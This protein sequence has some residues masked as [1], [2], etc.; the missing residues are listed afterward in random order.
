MKHCKLKEKNHFVKFSVCAS[1][2]VYMSMCEQV[3]IKGQYHMASSIAL[4]CGFEAAFSL[5]LEL[6]KSAETAMAL[7]WP[8]FYMGAGTRILVLML[9]SNCTTLQTQPPFRHWL[10]HFGSHHLVMT[11]WCH[12]MEAP[13]TRDWMMP[14]SLPHHSL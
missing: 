1:V 6:T 5:N 12:F 9:V 11:L 3:D 8:A 13:T 10:C 14:T 7:P 2:F 4:H